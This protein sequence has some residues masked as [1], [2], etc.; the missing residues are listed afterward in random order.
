MWQF[1]Q[2]AEADMWESHWLFDG[3][4]YKIIIQGYTG[5]RMGKLRL[6]AYTYFLLIGTDFHYFFGTDFIIFGTCLI[7]FC[8]DLII[9]G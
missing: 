4:G 5:E 3:V 2:D 6:E 9:F 1:M 8:T 7:N